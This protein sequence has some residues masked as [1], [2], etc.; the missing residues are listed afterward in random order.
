MTSVIRADR[1]GRVL[2]K[3]S[4][5]R[6]GPHGHPIAICSLCGWSESAD[7]PGGRAEARALA[8]QH[9]NRPPDWPVFHRGLASLIGGRRTNADYAA[10]FVDDV[11]GDTAAWALADGIGDRPGAA[12]AARIAA[13]TAVRAAFGRRI[14]PAEALLAARDEILRHDID[15]DTVMVVAVA[16]EQHE[17]Y[18]LAWVGD[19][20]GYESRDG[21]L[22]QLTT[23]H[24]LAEE[25]RAWLREN[26]DDPDS[27]PGWY[28]HRL[29]SWEHVVTSSVA[30]ATADTIGRT[31]TPDRETRLLLTSDGVHKPVPHDVLAQLVASTDN[32]ETAAHRIALA[33]PRHGGTDN[34][35]ALLI[36][37]V[38]GS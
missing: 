37:P 7:P 36:D 20:R 24:T 12:E 23:D 5:H 10:V 1:T 3:V 16:H 8:R 19:C 14:D 26:Y 22:R 38:P 6:A 17:G 11:F 18:E 27:V 21:H 35:T 25:T 29:P 33:G 15:G 2:H 4:T 31:S 9:L 34:S 28:A 13:T 32:V 30:T